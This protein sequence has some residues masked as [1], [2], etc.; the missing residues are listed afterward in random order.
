MTTSRGTPLLAR[1]EADLDHIGQPAFVVAP[2]PNGMVLREANEAFHAVIGSAPPASDNLQ[3]QPL[4]AVLPARAATALVAAAEVVFDGGDLLPLDLSLDVTG[5]PL[6]WRITMSP[7]LDE[8]CSLIAL[9]IIATDITRER[10]QLQWLSCHVAAQRN[11]LDA[12]RIATL[13]AVGDVA[14]DLRLAHGLGDSLLAKLAEPGIDHAELV[15]RL[16]VALSNAEARILQAQIQSWKDLHAPED[17]QIDIAVMCADILSRIDPG[18][19]MR[20]SYGEEI[21]TTNRVLLHG[22]LRALLD[23]ARTDGLNWVTVDTKD[24]APGRLCLTV[25]GHLPANASAIWAP[26]AIADLRTALQ[27]QGCGL[28]VVASDGMIRFRAELPGHCTTE[29]QAVPL[30]RVAL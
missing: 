11:L 13:E 20:C 5:G 26:T 30:T 28:E 18:D 9:H 14:S 1:L 15:E 25:A 21:L 7:V 16:R 10:R 29:E 22:T 17:D 2:G 19:D 8:A 4:T 6:W 27:S 3:A 24:V 23:Q 12:A